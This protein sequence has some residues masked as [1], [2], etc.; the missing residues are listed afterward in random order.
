M[1]LCNKKKTLQNTVLG[2]A[3]R[4]IKFSLLGF[5]F[6]LY[7][8]ELCKYPPTWRSGLEP[9]IKSQTATPEPSVMALLQ[10]LLV[11]ELPPSQEN[12]P[13]EETAL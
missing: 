10:H 3:Y 1:F 6:S 12:Q 4:D 8:S 13:G 7:N 11:K 9:R 2:G 5:F